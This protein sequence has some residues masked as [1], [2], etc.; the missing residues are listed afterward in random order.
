M[1]VLFYFIFYTYEGNFIAKREPKHNQ[2]L[3][4]FDQGGEKKEKKREV[5]L[6]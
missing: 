4:K 5:E 6:D 1:F 3:V 2:Y